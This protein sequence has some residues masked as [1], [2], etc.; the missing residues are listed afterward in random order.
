ME[1]P[2]DRTDHRRTICPVCRVRLHVKALANHKRSVRHIAAV[3]RK[4]GGR[5][6]DG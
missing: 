4:Q 2:R 3:L 5:K 1:V 6:R